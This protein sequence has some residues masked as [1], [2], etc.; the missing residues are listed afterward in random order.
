MHIQKGLHPRPSFLALA[1]LQCMN[2][3]V[4]KIKSQDT[5]TARKF[6][7]PFWSFMRKT[8]ERFQVGLPE[9]T[10][11]EQYYTPKTAD[12][13]FVRTENANPQPRAQKG[14]FLGEEVKWTCKYL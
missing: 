11:T 9:K 10:W 2:E 5:R 7:A 3:S 14:T 8:A 1:A 12:V 4:G 6:W 13:S